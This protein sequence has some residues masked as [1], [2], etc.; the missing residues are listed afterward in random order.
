MACRERLSPQAMLGRARDCGAL[1][2]VLSWSAPTEWMRLRSAAPEFRAALCEW[3][4][5][6]LAGAAPPPAGGSLHEVVGIALLRFGRD[7]D[8]DEAAAQREVAA[9]EAAFVALVRGAPVDEAQPGTGITALMRAAEESSWRLCELLLSRGADPDRASV[10]GGTALSLALGPFCGRCH[11]VAERPC[12]CSCPRPRVA[13]LL[14]SRTSKGLP[15][16][17]SATVR[18]ALQD[19]A[20]LPLLRLVVQERGLPVDAELHGPDCRIGTALSS[21]LERRVRPLEGPLVHRP[22]VVASLLELRADPARRGPYVAWCGG[23]PAESLAAFA[24][25]NRCEPA[26]LAVLRSAAERAPCGAAAGAAAGTSPRP[27]A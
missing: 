2:L 18:M 20:Y 14:L 19:A 23:P 10:G 7:A 13:R 8:A 1:G 27:T 6:A 16:A 26:T 22:D 15:E 5:R 17:F 9:C 24:A 21:A 12:P 3:Q 4:V 11:S 25:A